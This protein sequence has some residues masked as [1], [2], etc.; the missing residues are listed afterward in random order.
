MHK[1]KYSLMHTKKVLN[2]H[3]FEKKIGTLEYIRKYKF[4]EINENSINN[5]ENSKK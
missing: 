1:K 5:N 3:N 2:V 4:S